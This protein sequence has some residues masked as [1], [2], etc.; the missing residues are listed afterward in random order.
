EIFTFSLHDALPILE[1]MSESELYSEGC[2]CHPNVSFQY[3]EILHDSK[4]SLRYGRD[5]W[6]RHIDLPGPGFQGLYR[7]RGLWPQPRFHALDRKSTRL[8]SSHV[9]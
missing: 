3:K 1:V 2:L 8:N 7:G 5:G 9:K 4:D 6:H